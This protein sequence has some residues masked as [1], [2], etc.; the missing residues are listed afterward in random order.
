MT[1]SQNTR[2]QWPVL[3]L[4]MPTTS[5]ALTVFPIVGGSDEPADY[6]LLADAVDKGVASV[7]EVSGSGSVPVIRIVNKSDMLLLG[8][9]GEEYVGAK[10]NRSLNVSVLVAPG[11]SDVPVTCLEQGR[12]QSGPTHFHTGSYESPSL[13][14]MKMRHVMENRKK[15]GFKDKIAA[16]FADQGAVWDGVAD[17]SSKYGSRSPTQAYSDIYRS[18]D[19]AGAINKIESQMDMPEHARGAVIGIGGLVIGADFFESPMVFKRMWPRLLK[20]YALES[21][22]AKNVPTS[23]EAAMSFIAGP[24]AMTWAATPSVALGEDVR[25]QNESCLATA[26]FWQD[27]VLHGA[28]FKAMR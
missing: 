23:I 7:E 4:D 15:G 24:H 10:Q 25:W 18:K 26:L 5:G 21:V 28:A 11:K 3:E 22:H 2:F 27:R 14:S 9:Q 12:W 19:I 1:T 13:R 6:M 20:S 16:F 17:E 8:V